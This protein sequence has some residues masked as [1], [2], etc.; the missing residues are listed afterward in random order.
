[1]SPHIFWLYLKTIYFTMCPIKPINTVA[2]QQK[3]KKRAEKKR[4]ER[5][6]KYEN[7]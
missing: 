5:S 2:I 3:E 6:E 4:T 1:M 7:L